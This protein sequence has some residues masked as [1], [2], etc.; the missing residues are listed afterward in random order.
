MAGDRP[1][2]PDRPPGQEEVMTVVR[3]V[4]RPLLASMFVMGGIDTLRNPESRVP[5]AEDVAPSIASKLPYLPEDPEQLVK[6]NAVVQVGAGAML[7]IGRFPRLSALALAGSLVPTTLAGHRFWE[8]DDPKARKQQQ[9]HFFKNLGML[10]GLLLAAVDTEGR[11]GLAW[12]AQH[13]T[14][15]AST[16]A[17]RARKLA[18]LETRLAAREARL[19]AHAAR[20]KVA[21]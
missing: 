11:P 19:T 17:R 21:S 6:I 12:R 5:M 14:E 10:G 4:A 18:R 7:A 2:F 13:A 9:I 8:A 3:R 1:A 16:S 20:A 15:H